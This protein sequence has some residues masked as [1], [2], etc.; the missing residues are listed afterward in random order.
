LKRY[1]LI[2]IINK[3]NVELEENFPQVITESNFFGVLTLLQHMVSFLRLLFQEKNVTWTKSKIDK[4]VIAREDNIVDNQSKMLNSIL[5]WK[6]ETIILDKLFVTDPMTSEKF[7]TRDYSLIEE[8]VIKHF[9]Y[10][11]QD[12]NEAPP[13]VLLSFKEIS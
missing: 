5:E 8:T 7:L 9:K 13:K 12:V 6:K 3:Y 1:N 2:K 10:L 4:F 11:G